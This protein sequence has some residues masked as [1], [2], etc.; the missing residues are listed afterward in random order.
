MSPRCAGGT[1]LLEADAP[2]VT[3]AE[4]DGGLGLAAEKGRRGWE[5]GKEREV[6]KEVREGREKRHFVVYEEGK[7]CSGSGYS[8]QQS[9]DQRSLPIP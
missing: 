9:T 5:K 2:A 3:A 8:I 6:E 7:H 4:A 1:Y